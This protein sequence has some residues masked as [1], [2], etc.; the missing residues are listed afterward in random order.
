[1]Q[2]RAS[3]RFGRNPGS[4][5][6]GTSYGLLFFESSFCVCTR[7]RPSQTYLRRT[8]SATL[9]ISAYKE[10]KRSERLNPCHL[11]PSHANG[12]EWKILDISMPC[13]K[14]THTHTL[15][16][17]RSPMLDDHRSYLFPPSLLAQ[18]CVRQFSTIHVPA[19]ALPADQSTPSSQE[20]LN[21]SHSPSTLVSAVLP[22]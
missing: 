11:R 12:Q 14:N 4:S 16:P 1:M 8:N 17:Q 20:I 10:K 3:K 5:G 18:S 13:K 22:K 2:V 21:C 7:V 19:R 9:R 15:Q 6:P